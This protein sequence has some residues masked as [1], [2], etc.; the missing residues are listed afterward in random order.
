[1][2]YTTLTEP[3]L[4]RLAELRPKTL[5]TMHGSA[6]VGDGAR[7][8]RDLATIFKDVLGPI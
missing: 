3:A 8:L 1:M 7:A 5:A 6:Y 4:Y 2:P